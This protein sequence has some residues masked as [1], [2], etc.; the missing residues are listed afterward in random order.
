[1]CD[2]FNVFVYILFFALFSFIEGKSYFYVT[3]HIT[4]S[5][6]ELYCVVTFTMTLCFVATFMLGNFQGVCRG[7]NFFFNQNCSLSFLF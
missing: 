2:I 4:Y 6:F 3:R 5:L 1:M 7:S